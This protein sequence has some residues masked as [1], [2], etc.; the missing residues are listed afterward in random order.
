MQYQDEYEKI[1]KNFEDY[2]KTIRTDILDPRT[3]HDIMVNIYGNKVKLVTLASISVDKNS[4]IIDI[5]N[6]ES[7]NAIQKAL[8]EYDATFNPKL[9]KKT[10]IINIPP[11]T[12]ERKENMVKA[13][14]SK[15]ENYKQSILAQR[16]KDKHNID[17]MNLSEND[18]RREQNQLQKIVDATIE[19]LNKIAE[20]KKKYILC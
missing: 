18:E 4:Y 2:V 9:D 14:F 3:L 16:K 6:I 12:Y 1:I 8:I 20:T 5:W 7:I 17:Q 13:L 11:M 10:I 15:V 19:K